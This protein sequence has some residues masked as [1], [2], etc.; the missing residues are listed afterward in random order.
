[1]KQRR[2]QKKKKQRAIDDRIEQMQETEALIAVRDHKEV[3]TNSPTFR[4]INPSKSETSK[5]RNYILENINKL[6]LLKTK[7]NQ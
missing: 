2:L 4:P 5:I 3:F 6:L 7:V 1:M